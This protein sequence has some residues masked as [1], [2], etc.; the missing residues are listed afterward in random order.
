M[1]V[2]FR[3]AR[4]ASSCCVNPL[5]SLICLSPCSSRATALPP[6]RVRWDDSTCSCQILQLSDKCAKLVVME[7]APQ[8]LAPARDPANLLRRLT[9]Q[10]LAQPAHRP[11]GD[12]RELRA[13]ALAEERFEEIFFSLLGRTQT[14][15]LLPGTQPFR[16]RFGV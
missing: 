8:R 16:A 4:C 3:P 1:V 10:S 2:L 11:N 12:T 13:L 14:S 6:A 5:A 15:P 7:M 9:M